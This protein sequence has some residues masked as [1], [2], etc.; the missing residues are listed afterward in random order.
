MAHRLGVE[1]SCQT[2]CT[3]DQVISTASANL[4]QPEAGPSSLKRPCLEERISMDV[5]EDTISLG[6]NK[7]HPFIYEDFADSEFDEVDTMVL[8]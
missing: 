8:D 1:L 7:E 6:D 4:D 3:L 2:I 5:Q